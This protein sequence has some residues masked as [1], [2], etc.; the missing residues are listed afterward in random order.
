MRPLPAL[1]ALSI[2]GLICFGCRGKAPEAESEIENEIERSG[3][4]AE[5]ETERS[6]APVESERSGAPVESE[7]S[8]APVGSERSGAPVESERVIALLPPAQ[9]VDHVLVILIDTLRADA[10]AA[11]R[12]PHIDA[13]AEAGVAVERCWSAST[14]TVPSTI[15]L[16]TGMP[17]RQ[18]GWDLASARIGHYPPLPPTPTLAEVLR[19]AGVV[20]SGYYANPYLAEALG[21]DRGFGCWKRTVDAQM[22]RQLRSEVEREWGDGRRHF[23]YLH[24]FGVHSP[25]RP[26]D[27]ARARWDVDAAWI[28][29][30]RG[31][32]V[33]VAKRGKQE[34]SREAYRAAYHAVVEDLD[35]LVGELLDALGDQRGRTMVI[36]TSD[37]GELLGEHGKFAHGTHVWE[38]LTHVPLIV[39]GGHTALPATLGIASVPAL[40]TSALGVEHAWP[41]AADADLPLVSQREGLVALSPD[42]RTKGIWDDGLRVYDLSTDAAEEHP[43]QGR[44]AEL[45]A[46][47]ATW[48]ASI[49]AGQRMEPAVLLTDE[50]IEELRALGYVE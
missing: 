47:R 20:T 12:T 3:D 19:D 9:Q 43:L 25:L 10:V 45:E 32:L 18:H 29:P 17:V 11:A 6:G 49:P 35:A 48:E 15:S 34:G 41:T 28:D 40:V 7:R 24:L 44:D 37:H 16:M 50:M 38:G 33:E 13:L 5:S 42:G 30:Q 26:S 27:E 22:P 31:F 4:P 23:T 46:S 14:W 39:H 21:F 2:A 8:G 1:A 36:L